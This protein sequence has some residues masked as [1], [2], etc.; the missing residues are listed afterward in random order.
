MSTGR[1]ALPAA[2]ALAACGPTVAEG[3]P[4]QPAAQV[5]VTG[6]GAHV[7]MPARVTAVG[8]EVPAAPDR[9]WAVLGDVYREL[10]MEPSA[11]AAARVMAAEPRAFTRRFGGL[12]APR[13]FDCGRGAAG[14]DLASTY[15]IR[16]SVRTALHPSGEGGTRLETTVEAHGRN[17]DGVDAVPARCLSRGVLEQAIATRVTAKL[18]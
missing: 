7:S 10:G 18:F 11:D 17:P 1:F 12:P 13:L 2:L 15:R 14:V 8:S 3:P 16:M 5:I 9:V 6:D 4:P